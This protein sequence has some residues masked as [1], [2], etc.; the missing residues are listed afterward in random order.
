M[1]G[2]ELKRDRTLAGSSGTGYKEQRTE[3][4]GLPV[5]ALAYDCGF[6]YWP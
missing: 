4:D 3:R 5:T 2:N 6:D 1:R